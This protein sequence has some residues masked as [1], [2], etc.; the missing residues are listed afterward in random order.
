MFLVDRLVHGSGLRPD[1]APRQLRGGTGD[2]IQ[3]ALMPRP[4]RTEPKAPRPRRPSV[5]L[6]LALAAPVQ[7]RKVG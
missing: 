2:L 4:S 1:L 3:A 5:Q 6:D 7:R